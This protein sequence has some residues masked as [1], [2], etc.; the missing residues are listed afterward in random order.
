SIVM[1]LITRFINRY[2][3]D[4]TGPI[5]SLLLAVFFAGVSYLIVIVKVEIPVIDNLKH[6]LYKK[7]KGVKE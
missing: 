7:M 6:D 5:I 2:F 4:I 3:S 1:V